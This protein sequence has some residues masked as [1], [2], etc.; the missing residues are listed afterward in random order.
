[1]DTLLKNIEQICR[2][3]KF[4]S[5]EEHIQSL[6]QFLGHKQIDLVIL[7]QFKAGK[8]SFINSF[9]GRDLVPTG[10]IPVTSV[11]TRLQQAET[12]KL[13]VYFRDKETVEE[14]LSNINDY[15]SEEKNPENEKN[16]SL[17]EI[18][19][20]LLNQFN[21]LC[22]V[23]TPGLG[24]AFRH[25]S[26]TTNK[27]IP[28]AGVA[29][30]TISA[31]RPLGENEIELIK[32][33]SKS[34][35]EVIILLTKTDLF[36]KEEIHQIKS[37]IT[38]RLIQTFNSELRIF[39]YS[40]VSN[41]DSYKTMIIHEIIEPLI[42]KFKD[43]REKIIK[44]KVISLA[45]KCLSYLEI[46][47]RASLKSDKEKDYLCKT[48]FGE[49][50]NNE[51]IRQELNLISDNSK[52]KTR[53]IVY[54]LLSKYEHVI[55]EDLQIAFKEEY[56]DWDGNLYAVSRKYEEWLKL[57][58]SGIL[59]EAVA[60]ENS[61]FTEI[62]GK[63]YAH[64]SF[65]TRSFRD[66][67]SGNIF[68]VLGIRLAS[69]E[70]EPDVKTLEG[71]DVSVYRAFDTPIDLLWFLFPMFVFKNVFRNYLLRQIPREVNKNI[72]RLTSAINKT[73]NDEISKG[74]TQTM[75][76]LL[77]ETKTVENLLSS[78]QSKSADIEKSRIELA[79][80]ITNIGKH[81]DC[82]S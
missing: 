78:Q 24:S 50:A 12:E 7:G 67:L 16:V 19:S 8:S 11:I 57:S 71:P 5:L 34:T 70:W 29:F 79:G 46:A 14:K 60:K 76:Y 36:D 73:I 41:T 43:E 63:V 21:G 68:K 1:M 64:F 72:Y 51:F 20:P 65:F 48:I 2:Q 69:E 58:L 31:E 53:D 39:E 3:H 44:H 6:K 35:P 4:H 9:L 30:I 62:V 77:D 81:P 66:K 15:V 55:T 28:E 18:R 17:V 13:L 54:G 49:K 33:I 75:N 42:L 23:D 27:W 56:N 22:F 37:F 82:K 61:N 25:N 80:M 40:S 32:N 47:F 38:K 10:V 74:N 52:S 59:K 26:I 45:G